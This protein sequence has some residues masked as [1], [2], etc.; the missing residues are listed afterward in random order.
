[1]H[2]NRPPPALVDEWEDAGQPCFGPG[3]RITDQGL[4]AGRAEH[5]LV[6]LQ[7]VTAD[8]IHQEQ[9]EQQEQLL[10]LGHS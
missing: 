8:D 7:A 3:V 6:H 2:K 10:L 1:M 4:A 9:Q 5:L